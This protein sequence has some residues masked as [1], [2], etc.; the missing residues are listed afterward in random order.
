VWKGFLPS[1]TAVAAAVALYASSSNNRSGSSNLSE[2][3]AQEFLQLSHT[4]KRGG[5]R[6]RPVRASTDLRERARLFFEVARSLA[7]RRS[8]A[9][10]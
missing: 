4:F 7:R 10:H 6:R 2:E 5:R 1:A 9:G 8:S 3:G